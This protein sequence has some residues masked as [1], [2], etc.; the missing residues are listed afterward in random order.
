LAAHALEPAP[1]YAMLHLISAAAR[2]RVKLVPVLLYNP[3]LFADLCAE[4]L[5]AFATE[6]RSRSRGLFMERVLA[7]V[8]AVRRHDDDM[9]AAAAAAERPPQRGG[10]A[11]SSS[12]EEASSTI[13]WWELGSSE[14]L[15]ALGVAGAAGTAETA[16]TA[17][18]GTELGALLHAVQP[19][20]AVGLPRREFVSLRGGSPP[21]RPPDERHGAALA[22][23]PELEP[24][25][26]KPGETGEPRHRHPHNGTKAAADPAATGRRRQQRHV[27]TAWLALMAEMGLEARLGGDSLPIASLHNTR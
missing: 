23:E 6:P 14:A 2:A 16:A 10:W 12:T 21:S 11:L 20:S 1:H 26:L 22:P 7:L 17:G 3:Y 13:A 9:M 18:A 19:N 4:P 24:P 25:Q 27:S 8:R 15:A 5:P